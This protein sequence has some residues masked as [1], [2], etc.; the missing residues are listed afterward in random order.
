MSYINK[1]Q[2]QLIEAKA[3]AALISS[4]NDIRWACGFTGSNGLLVVTSNSASLITDGRYTTQS[5]EET[6]DVDI[7]I[8]DGP[9][10]DCIKNEKLFPSNGAIILQADHVTIA[11]HTKLVVHFGERDWLPKVMWLS[12]NVAAKAPWE[13]DNI[14][15]AQQIT[16]DVFNGLLEFIQVGQT[17]QEI[18]AEIVYQ[19]MIRGAS[20]MSFDPIVA[21]GPNGALPHARP[22]S[23]VLQAGDLVVLDF[24][25][26]V[27]G[28][29]S[30]MTRTIA[31]GKPTAKAVEVY[32]T[33]LEA[34][35][36][37]ISTASASLT[38]KELDATARSVI[39][40]AG[41]GEYFT[42]SLGHGVGLDIHEWPR[43]S[44]Q[45]E[46]QLVENAVVTIEPGVYLPN[47]LGVRIEDMVVLKQDGCDVLTKSSKELFVLG[48]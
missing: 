44:W 3:T 1:I 23:R 42:H 25:C 30:D 41:Y 38:A 39:T 13:I 15:K 11:Q 20:R 33:V 4:L 43:I 21:S 8:A 29:A 19:H 7:Y 34:Q 14:K 24:G 46:D 45:S 5:K 31:I 2:E 17:E 32:N 27:N 12:R 35:Q 37:A 36:N 28:Y 9:L 26:F 47:N 18:A 22:S 16:D 40:N 6:D 10:I 48:V